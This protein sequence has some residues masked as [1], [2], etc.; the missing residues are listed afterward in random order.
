M[1]ASSITSSA[2][3]PS[4]MPSAMVLTLNLVLWNHINR[5]MLLELRIGIRLHMT[6]NDR[7]LLIMNLRNRNW[8][9]ILGI[10]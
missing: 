2:V 9:L 5:L 3:M 7:L 6:H 8:L 1:M 10:N 4:D